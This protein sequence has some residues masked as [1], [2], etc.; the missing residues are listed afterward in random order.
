MLL[1]LPLEV[2]N[3][4]LILLPNQALINL[5]RVCKN[6][7][8]MID[9]NILW[10][11]K[12]ND[13]FSI[14]LNIHTLSRHT[15]FRHRYFKLKSYIEIFIRSMEARAD[16]PLPS[17]SAAIRLIEIFRQSNYLTLSKN[18]KLLTLWYRFVINTIIISDRGYVLSNVITAV[19]MPYTVLN[20]F[21]RIDKHIKSLFYRSSTTVNRI[22]P[23]D[24][25]QFI[26]QLVCESQFESIHI[27]IALL[28]YCAETHFLKHSVYVENEEVSVC[29]S[30]NKPILDLCV[31]KLKEVSF[32]DLIIQGIVKN[33]QPFRFEF[34]IIVMLIYVAQEADSV[35]IVNEI[36]E[37]YGRIAINGARSG[38]RCILN[39]L[40]I[41]IDI[42]ILASLDYTNISPISLNHLR[43]GA[44]IQ[45]VLKFPNSMT[46]DNL[47]KIINL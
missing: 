40:K 4:I 19:P 14:D 1:T 31:K 13:E 22:N 43:E 23:E 7:Q 20:Q 39:W 27:V 2:R 25:L 8:L 44:I 12:A 9:N 10:N 11:T 15:L 5:C 21:G 37:H 24:A 30:E 41:C 34:A 33:V 18:S 17:P 3:L 47:I 35:I 29:M 46:R 16:V 26:D 42:N 32:D 36:L 38:L 6:F 45:Y 28:N